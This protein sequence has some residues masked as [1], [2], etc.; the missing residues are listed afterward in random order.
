[1]EPKQSFGAFERANSYG[2]AEEVRS[3]LNCSHL[4]SRAQVT[5]NTAFNV[6]RF[7]ALLQSILTE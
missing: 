2:L 7:L 3:M 6:I 1:M 5:G 4:L